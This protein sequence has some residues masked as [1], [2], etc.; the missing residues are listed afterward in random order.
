MRPV[1]T[2]VRIDADDGDIVVDTRDGLFNHVT[3]FVRAQHETGAG[4]A[5]DIGENA[6]T[7]DKVQRCRQITAGCDAGE[8]QRRPY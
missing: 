1:G 6:R 8:A 7:G 5:E 2:F 3:L 4:M